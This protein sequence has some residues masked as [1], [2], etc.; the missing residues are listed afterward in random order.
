MTYEPYL[1]H[2]GIKGQKW[3]VRRFQE[4]NGTMTPKGLKRYAKYM[5]KD[6]KLNDKGRKK[7]GTKEIFEKAGTLSGRQRRK[8]R[9]AAILK[10]RE[11]FK[12]A[13]ELYNK[14]SSKAANRW[15]QVFD[16]HGQT[17]SAAKKANNDKTYKRLQAAAGRDFAKRNSFMDVS[18]LRTSKETLAIVRDRVGTVAGISVVGL[19][20][21]AYAY[22]KIKGK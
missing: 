17:S 3:G 14:S 19:I 10:A 11:N 9:D 7:Y 18:T 21:G 4:E 6:G 8:E 5:D 16:T 22:D 15:E 2:H 20:A 1:T 12:K 13:D